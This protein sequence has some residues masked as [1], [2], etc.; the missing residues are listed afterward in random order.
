MPTPIPSA[1]VTRGEE[2]VPEPACRRLP[3]GRH[4]RAQLM[5]PRRRL[6]KVRVGARQP[7][8]VPRSPQGQALPRR[9]ALLWGASQHLIHALGD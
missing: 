5:Q 4:S 8:D 7:A 1:T 9:E 2:G 3:R 6:R